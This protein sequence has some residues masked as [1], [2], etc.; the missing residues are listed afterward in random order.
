MNYLG[1]TNEEVRSILDF[2]KKF[3]DFT[4]KSTRITAPNLS[5]G[6]SPQFLVQ[7]FYNFYSN[8]FFKVSFKS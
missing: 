3:N 7:Y 5:N 1:F 8:P 2:V 4:Q 6:L